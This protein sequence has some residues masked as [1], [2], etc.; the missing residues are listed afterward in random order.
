MQLVWPTSI[1]RNTVEVQELQVLVLAYADDTTYL[2]R[3]KLELEQILE[4]AEEF[5]KVNDIEINTKKSELLALNMCNKKGIRDGINFGPNN[6]FI[7]IKK[8]KELTR[9]LGVWIS[10]KAEI[11]YAIKIGKEEIQTIV[12]EIKRKKASLAYMA[13]INNVV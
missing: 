6:E 5:Y 10:E 7:P 3:N 8:E 12:S 2:A 11:Q 13:Y 9:F 1:R 4:V